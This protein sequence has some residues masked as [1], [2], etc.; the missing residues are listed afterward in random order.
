MKDGNHINPKINENASLPQNDSN[1]NYMEEDE[2]INPVDDEKRIDQDPTIID[3]NI[4]DD[5]EDF[6][7]GQQTL[8][9][10]IELNKTWIEETIF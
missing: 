1:V 4:S 2:D 10:K 7:C 9:S 6:E 5:T 8:C 3:A